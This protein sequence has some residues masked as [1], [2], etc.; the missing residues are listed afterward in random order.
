M[1]ESNVPAVSIVVPCRNERN[2]IESCFRSILEQEPPPG[3]FEILVADG[4][5]NDGTRETLKRLGDQYPSLRIIDNPQ[6][7]VS[8]AL[9]EAIK[10]ARGDIIIRMDAHTDYARDY[11]RECMKVLRETHADNVGGP[12]RAIGDGVIGGA[13][14][15]AFQSPF[16]VGGARGHD[17]S[18]EGIVDTVY[19]G[20]WPRK[21]FDRIGSFDEELVRNQDDEF[22][23]RLTRAGGKIWQSPRIRSWYNPRGSLGAL[24]RQYSQYGYWKVRVIQKHKIPASVRHLIPG[25]FVLLSCV[26]PLLGL[27]WHPA[28][29]AWLIMMAAYVGCNFIASI[30]AARRFGAQYLV[31]FPIVFASYHAA[32]GYGFLRGLCDF[33][34]FKRK[35][36]ESYTALTRE[37]LTH[38]RTRPSEHNS[39]AEQA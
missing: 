28:M 5:S 21:V 29:Q 22:N 7:I 23:L 9:N 3:G 4:M 37:S 8:S 26:L 18:Y 31:M 20:C 16:A 32:Y 36:R 27:E 13:I 6:C 14:A 10:A 35:P 17:P 34:L 19:L 11:V 39:N 1:T 33:I 15:A 12:W 30:F 25:I 2:H 38:E 24:F